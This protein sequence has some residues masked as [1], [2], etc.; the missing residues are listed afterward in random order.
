MLVSL[1][2]GWESRE[3]ALLE[4][5]NRTLSGARAAC[6]SLSSSLPLSTT[7]SFPSLCFSL[8]VVQTS[9]PQPP[10]LLLFLK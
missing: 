4:P 7:L 1:R 5:G 3:I 2:G 9:L 6:M 10:R 8:Y